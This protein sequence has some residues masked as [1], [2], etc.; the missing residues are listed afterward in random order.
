VRSEV[1]EGGRVR[2]INNEGCQ[3]P[4]LVPRSSPLSKGDI[5]QRKKQRSA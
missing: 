1:P 3:T 5:V 2:K 4:P